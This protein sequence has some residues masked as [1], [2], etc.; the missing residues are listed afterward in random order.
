MTWVYILVAAAMLILA[1]VIYREG[2]LLRRELR[3]IIGAIDQLRL[4]SR[5]RINSVATADNP[6]G[7]PMMTRVSRTARGK[8]VAVGGSQGSKQR[9][10]LEQ[11]LESKRK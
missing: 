10:D 1:F 2:R 5:A 7:R 8:R 4:T 11:S 3:H 6:A 9:K